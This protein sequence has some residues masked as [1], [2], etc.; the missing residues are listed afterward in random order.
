[1]TLLLFLVVLIVREVDDTGAIVRL[2]DIT[3]LPEIDM[4]LKRKAEVTFTE[5][6]P[7]SLPNSSLIHPQEEKKLTLKPLLEAH[8]LEGLLAFAALPPGDPKRKEG[9]RIYGP[10]VNVR[11]SL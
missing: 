3:T 2:T 4:E 6:P 11:C 7:P 8:E 10:V 5:V 9:F 1:M